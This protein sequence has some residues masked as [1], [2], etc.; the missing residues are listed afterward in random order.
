MEEL[1]LQNEI[2]DAQNDKAAFAA[3]MD[4]LKI[5]DQK[6]NKNKTRSKFIDSTELLLL[7]ARLSSG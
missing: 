1:R 4:E 5:R 6:S 2:K 3:D 7:E